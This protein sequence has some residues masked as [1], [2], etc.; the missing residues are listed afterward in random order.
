MKWYHPLFLVLITQL[1]ACE[2]KA[3][4]SSGAGNS[5][6]VSDRA[7]EERIRV[8]REAS[9]A[10][11]PDLDNPEHYSDSTIVDAMRALTPVGSGFGVRADGLVL[12]NWHVLESS[13]RCVIGN[14]GESDPRTPEVV[15]GELTARKSGSVATYC[16]LMNQERTKSFRAKLVSQDVVND[17]AAL[18]IVN[19]SSPL[20]ALSI[21]PASEVRVGA[22]VFTIGSPLGKDNVLTHGYIGNT[23]YVLEDRESGKKEAPKVQI[24][25]PILSGNSGGPLVSVATGKVV[26]Q[27]VAVIRGRDQTT[28]TN[29]SFTNRVDEL[30]LLV[31][32]TP[33]CSS[34]AQ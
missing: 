7:R 16:A 17:I 22:E 1:G 25:A 32:N 11:Y 2:M 19:T 10:V 26:G 9:Y 3:H 27:V 28:T 5:T 33:P 21:A 14:D 20:P 13:H 24:T 23:N 8:T 29:I 34:K 18:C 31:A 6:E 15:K 30:N 4:V 12:T